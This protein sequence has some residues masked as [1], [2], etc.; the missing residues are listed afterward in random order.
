MN[1]A[2]YGK[3]INKSIWKDRGTLETKQTLQDLDAVMKI[4][5]QFFPTQSL[6]SQIANIDR[7][8]QSGGGGSAGCESAAAEGRAAAR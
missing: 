7:A 1:P 6:P 3:D 4:I 8:V 5:D 2:G